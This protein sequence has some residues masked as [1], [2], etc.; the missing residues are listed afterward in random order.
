MAV[1]FPE[2]LMFSG[3]NAPF[4]AEVDVLDL[5][6]D[7]EL[8][9]DMDGAFYRVQP[10]FIYPPRCDNDIPFN[11]D[12]HVSMFRFGNGHVDF[13]C[14]YVQTQRYKAQCDARRA[15]FGTYRNRDTDDPSVRKLSAGTANT[16][17]VFHAGRLFA[18]KEDSPPVRMDPDT[19]ETLDDCHTFNGRLTSETFTAHPKLDPVSGEMVGYG[20]EAKGTGTDDVAVYAIDRSGNINWEAWIKAPYAGMLHDFAVTQTHVAFLL[21]PMLVDVEQMRQGGVHFSWDDTMPTWFGVLRRGGDGRDVRWFKGPTRMATHV[22]NAFSDGERVF[23]D[24]DMAESNQ[25]P[26]FRSRQGPFDPMRAQGRLTRLS[27]D[28]SSAADTYD[29]EILYPHT[30][31]LPRTDE[32]YWSIPYSVGFMPVMDP[33]RP[34][35]QQRIGNT[36]LVLNT[37]TRFD[38]GSGKASSYYAGEVSSL[39][40]CQ[41][42]PRRRDAPEGDGWLIGLVN[43]YVDM[44]TDLLVLDAQHLEDGP[45]ATVRLP[46]RLRNGI[47]GTWVD[48]D[49]LRASAG[50]SA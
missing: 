7:G 15:L 49:A 39:Q 27:V 48:G 29:M 32:R 44:R 18:L 5:E 16:N 28:L 26:F 24:M 12:G 21:I 46:F 42:V 33:A 47:H 35:D 13:R 4:R 43:R 17:L 20:Y 41:F 50:K 9:A 8:P 38:H 3:F 11:G 2:N 34:V 25:F 36:G 30:G 1:K 31:V 10:D 19:L 14:R 37:W 22:M 40:E 45:V 6:V 23:A